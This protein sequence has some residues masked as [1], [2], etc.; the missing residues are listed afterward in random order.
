[1]K[2]VNFKMVP[3]VSKRIGV[4]ILPIFLILLGIYASLTLKAKRFLSP[5]DIGHF[6]WTLAIASLVHF[7][8]AGGP[9]AFSIV[10]EA[11]SEQAVTQTSVKA[12]GKNVTLPLPP[13][14]IHASCNRIM[15]RL[16]EEPTPQGP[17]SCQAGAS[18][19]S[20]SQY[21]LT[22]TSGENFYQRYLE[23]ALPEAGW[24]QSDRAGGAVFYTKKG[25][26]RKMMMLVGSYLTGNIVE[27]IIHEPDEFGNTDMLQ[28]VQRNP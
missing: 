11:I 15:K 12:D 28:I 8:T 3:G 7:D 19:P 6:T 26:T 23:K 27:F 2:G 4:R 20:E 16:P 13:Y 14:T 1:M 22:L 18:F 5:Q 25:H 17:P 21:F 10:L 24:V 9:R